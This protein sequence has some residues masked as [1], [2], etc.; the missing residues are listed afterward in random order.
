MQV[1]DTHDIDV[2]RLMYNLK[3]YSDNY[4]KTCG[5]SRQYCRDEPA[6]KAAD[7]NIVNFDADNAATD[8]F[9]IKEKKTSQT[10]D[11]GT[12]NVEIMVPLKYLSNFWRTFEMFLI[13]CEINLDL[14]WSK[15]C[16]IV[17][18]NADQETIFSITDTKLYVSVVTY[19]LKIMLNCLNN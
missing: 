13:N 6:I 3:E 16:I 8:S 19:Q 18:N 11:N 5:I 17:A 2:V 9:E 7:E 14:N 15:N 1:D 12:K 10:A 4:S